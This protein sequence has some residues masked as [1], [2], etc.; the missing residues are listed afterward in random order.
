MN[1]QEACAFLGVS[2]RSLARYASQGKV[3]VTYTKGTRGNVAVYDDQDLERL[4]EELAAPTAIRPANEQAIPANSASLAKRPV[5]GVA[6]FF[7]QL[8]ARDE[9]LFQALT[10]LPHRNQV[11]IENKLTLNLAEGAQLSG[12]SK[13][14][15]RDAIKTGKLKA[16][17]IG[18][19]WRMKRKDLETYIQKL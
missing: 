14:H 15:L 10:S 16:K 6:E 19:G 5:A 9:A 3:Q 1:K 7:N 2:E 17:I 8:Q 4:K 11:A 13:Q 18:R 12:L